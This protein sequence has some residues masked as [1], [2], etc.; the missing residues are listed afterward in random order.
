MKKLILLLS[1]VVLFA[2]CKRCWECE[3][4]WNYCPEK[5]TYPIDGQFMPATYK[6]T[7]YTIETF[8]QTFEPKNVE[9]FEVP[10]HPH[11]SVQV[12]IKTEKIY[13]IKK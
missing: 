1:I 13:C 6:D 8:C 3:V 4:R 9:H 11:S 2:S 10:V 12:T 7:F 5:S